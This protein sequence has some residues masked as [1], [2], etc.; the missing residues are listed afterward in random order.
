[1]HRWSRTSIL[2]PPRCRARHC[3]LVC[4]QVPARLHRAGAVCA[5]PGPRRPAQGAPDLAQAGRGRAAVQPVPQ[6]VLHAG[7]CRRLH[8]WV[9]CGVVGTS[10]GLG[11]KMTVRTC[12][13]WQ[14]GG[15]WRGYCRRGCVVLGA[16]DGAWVPKSFQ[17]RVA[18]CCRCAPSA[19]HPPPSPGP[20]TF[21]LHACAPP[22]PP[23]HH[24]SC[25]QGSGPP[26][27]ATDG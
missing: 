7:L 10:L 14:G 21:P 23:Q 9:H 1:M 6:H 25:M 19:P 27:C 15:A 26:G 8:R 20:P 4:P 12:N 17:T 16:L 13:G 2:T 24:P 22:P 3:P 5:R 18:P 11:V